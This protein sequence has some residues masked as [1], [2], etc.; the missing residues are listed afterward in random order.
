MSEHPADAAAQDVR[1]EDLA[2]AFASGPLL[3]VGAGKMGGAMVS[4]LF[5]RGLDPSLV[6]VQDPAPPADIADLLARHGVT[7]E[8]AVPPS[9][10]A[11]LML[12]AVKPQIMADLLPGLAPHVGPETLVVS[13]AAGKPLSLFEA[14]F[15]AGAAIVRAMPN[16][17]AAIGRGITALAANAAVTQTQKAT[18]E[19]LLGVLGDVVWLDDEGQMDAVTAVSGS[20]PAYVF[21]L[22]EAMTEAG[23]AAGLPPDLAG[24]LARATVTGA[25]ALLDAESATDAATLRKNVTSPGGTTEAALGVLMRD[26]QGLRALLRE[27]VEAAAR[28]SRELSR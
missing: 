10:P 14:A 8:A 16:T 28:R 1:A 5:A 22:V 2:A 12:L 23:V 25:G 19:T 26:E 3:L 4:G 7:P 20:G 9:V 21:H 18:C 13:I 17:P 11:G 6:K 15:P 24:R 27:A